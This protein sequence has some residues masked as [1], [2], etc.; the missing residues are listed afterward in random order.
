MTKNDLSEI[1]VPILVDGEVYGVID[2]EHP[3]KGFYKKHHRYILQSIADICAIRIAKYLAEEKLRSKIARDLHDDM[4]STLSSINIISKMALQN[5]DNDAM[6]KEYLLK[7]KDN[8]GRMLESMSDIV[9]AINPAND[10]VEKVILRM[11]E[12]TA[13]MLEPLNISLH[14]QRKRRF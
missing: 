6:A 10:T 13:E 4:G 3:R 5:N 7:I 11:K 14:F 9:W 2:S 8:S 12:F 1:T